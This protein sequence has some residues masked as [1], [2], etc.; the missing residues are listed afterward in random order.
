MISFCIY[1]K[2]PKYGKK[3]KMYIPTHNLSP[4]QM[5]A[6]EL[7]SKY[8]IF[9]DNEERSEQIKQMAESIKNLRHLNMLYLGAS[10]YIIDILGENLEILKSPDFYMT[11]D[12]KALINTTIRKI[13]Y[14]LEKDGTPSRA[15]KQKE[16]LYT[17][18][19]KILSLFPHL[20]FKVPQ[21][22]IQIEEDAF[23][24]F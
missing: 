4:N 21:N 5:A 19:D 17:Y 2:K 8:K 24:E 13:N 7:K 10:F 11:D 18:I 14:S 16:V 20:Q 9:N 3:D 12:P 23:E 6:Y 1:D 15:K 22:Q